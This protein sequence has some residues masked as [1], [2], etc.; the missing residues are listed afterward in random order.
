IVPGV[1]R[2]K[3][4]AVLSRSCIRLRTLTTANRDIALVPWRLGPVLTPGARRG[5]QSRTISDKST[6]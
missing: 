1:Q 2:A 4:C 6:S 5:N 3:C